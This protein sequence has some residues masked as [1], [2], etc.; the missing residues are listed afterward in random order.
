[1]IFLTR[2]IQNLVWGWGE[3][4]KLLNEVNLNEKIIEN[5]QFVK[6]LI[7]DVLVSLKKTHFWESIYLRRFFH[8]YR[9][10]CIVKTHHTHMT[11]SAIFFRQK[12]GKWS[13]L[14]ILWPSSWFFHPASNYHSSIWW[15]NREVRILLHFWRCF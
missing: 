7:R 6:K 3:S 1:M 10:V 12:V 13:K 11:I 14:K 15:M 9:S 4:W 5:I 8:V 2:K